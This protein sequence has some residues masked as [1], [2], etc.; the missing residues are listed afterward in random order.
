MMDQRLEKAFSMVKE[1]VALPVIIEVAQPGAAIMSELTSAGLTRITGARV[2]PLVYGMATSA[3]AR[4]IASNPGVV[5]VSYNEPIFTAAITP[6]ETVHLSEKRIVTLGETVAETGAPALWEEGYTGKGVGIALIDTGVCTSHEMLRDA[7][8]GSY[9]AVPN[10]GIEDVQNHGSWTASA[11]LGRKAYLKTGFVIGAAPEAD[12]YAL[13]ALDKNGSGQMSQ[14][15]DC[16]EYAVTEFKTP[17]ISMSLGSLFD[18]GGQ[19]PISRT[20]NQFVT[21]NGIIAV[22]A[23][24]NSGVMMSIGSPGGAASALTVG[25][26]AL[27]IPFKGAPSTFSSKGP[28]TSMMVKP[29]VSAPGGNMLAPDIGELIVGAAAND[30]YAYMCGTSMATPQVAGCIACLKQAKPTLTRAD[31]ESLLLRSSA[32]RP[33]EIV[34]GYGPV[35]ADV[36]YKNI[37]K[38]TT[39]LDQFIGSMAQ[40]QTIPYLPFSLIPSAERDTSQEI[41]L[42]AIMG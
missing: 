19:D 29:D 38:P 33:K 20:V 16:I 17:I 8:K 10:E 7:L 24:G 5:K 25:S 36:M 12:L 11:A 34:L 39:A 4:A 31:V 27:Q 26:Y 30:E 14:V 35:R 23:A 40:L 13:K 3:V 32:P 2:T 42:P 18:N 6:F 41:R 9:S 1:G 22:I 15:I 21:Q 37:D 28:T